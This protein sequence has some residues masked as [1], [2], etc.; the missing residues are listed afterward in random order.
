MVG[1]SPIPR[2]GSARQTGSQ[3]SLSLSTGPSSA[4]GEDA[5][6]GFSADDALSTSNPNHRL[7]FISY[8]DLLV[9]TPLSAAPL[10]S[11]TSG[12]SQPAPPQSHSQQTPASP[13][14]GVGVDSAYNIF[15]HGG[16][17]A[18]PGSGTSSPPRGRSTAPVSAVSGGGHATVVGW[19]KDDGGEWEREGLGKGLE[20]R[21]E[22]MLAAEAENERVKQVQEKE[23]NGVIVEQ[24]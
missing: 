2:G 7:S 5:F 14:S 21:L 11:I 8:H 18:S 1:Q 23:K 20:E 6:G 19:G 12:A 16:T 10:S 24:A 3:A 9:S 17:T 22:G 15:S 13:G 4:A